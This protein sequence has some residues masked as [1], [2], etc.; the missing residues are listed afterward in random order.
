LS[1]NLFA[2]NDLSLTAETFNTPAATNWAAGENVVFKLVV[3]NDGLQNNTSVNVNVPTPANM[4]FQSA[5]SATAGTSFAGTT[6]SIGNTLTAATDSVFIELTYQINAGTNGI[7]TIM[8]EISTMTETDTDS[9]PG[10]GVL[11]EDDFGRH[12]TYWSH[13]LS[14]VQR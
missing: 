9:T 1:I 4:T 2:Q 8:P 7:Y 12:R 11:S 5:G 13:K 14:M 10:N 6:W 3:K